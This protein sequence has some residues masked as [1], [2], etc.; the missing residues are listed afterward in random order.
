M[1]A[2][3]EKSSEVGMVE[4]TPGSPVTICVVHSL[5]YLWSWECDG[6][7]SVVPE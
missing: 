5:L 7:V 2:V 3:D 4:L 6:S 1:A